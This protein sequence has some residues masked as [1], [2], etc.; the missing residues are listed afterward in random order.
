MLSIVVFFC[1]KNGSNTFTQITGSVLGIKMCS[2][3][4]ALENWE[5][6]RV[7]TG[8]PGRLQDVFSFFLSLFKIYLSEKGL[9]FV[10]L[11]VLE[12]PL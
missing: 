3:F 11:S 6:G 5:W 10:S 2:E 7:H 12:F 4:G 9:F 8:W 1:V